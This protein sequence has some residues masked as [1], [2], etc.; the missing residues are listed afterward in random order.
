MKTIEKETVEKTK[1]GK[2]SKISGRIVNRLKK[3]MTTSSE[4]E[5]RRKNKFK[6]GQEKMKVEI[7]R[8][9]NLIA[10]MK[11]RKEKKDSSSSEEKTN[12]PKVM[13]LLSLSEKDVPN[14]LKEIIGASIYDKL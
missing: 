14:T 13:T 8:L 2:I 4:E 1:V 7:R 11:D 9:Q 5:P 3:I 12:K 6:P 10:K